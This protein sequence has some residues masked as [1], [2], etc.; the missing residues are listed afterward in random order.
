VAILPKDT[1]FGRK[2]E[3]DQSACNKDFSCLKGFCPSFVTVYG[4]G[5]K[6]GV[7]DAE[8][9]DQALTGLPDPDQPAIE[10]TYDIVLTG[11]GGTGVVTVGAI[12][13]MAAHVSE[14]GCSILDMMGL[15]QKGGAVMSH[16]ILANQPSDVTATHIAAGGA[17]LLLGCD[18]VVAAS[19]N[20]VGRA[21]P[22]ATFAVVN[23]FEMMTGDFTHDPD[24]RFPGEELKSVIREHT[25]A[26]NAVFGDA[27]A[28][29]LHRRQ[30]VHAGPRL[31]VGPT[32]ASPRRH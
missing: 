27:A 9:V 13:G 8:A 28:R 20:A 23:D 17:E 11:V 6:R 1:V 12:L 5:P 22:G 29:Q 14:K 32:P 4:G 10:G 18:L 31:P 16:I 7:S 15:A 2:R 21:H 26:D 3:I 30:H 25:G 19:P 24:S